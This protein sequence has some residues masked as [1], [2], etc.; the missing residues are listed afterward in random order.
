MVGDEQAEKIDKMADS[1]EGIDPSKFARKDNEIQRHIHRSGPQRGQIPVEN[2]Q[3]GFVYMRHPHIGAFQTEN[4]R[5][6]VR[7]SLEEAFRWG[8]EYVDHDDPEDRKFK[9]NDCAA[10]TNR[11]GIGDVMT[12]R[13]TVENFR[14]MQEYHREQQRRKGQVEERIVL[15]GA[16]AGVPAWGGDVSKDPNLAARFGAAAAQPIS[17]V[18]SRDG[19]QTAT[20]QFTE[21]DIRRG[22][23]P[24]VPVGTG[25]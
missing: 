20:A 11:R 16:G 3:P 15:L 13:I 2:P 8:W 14:K 12:L 22:S 5:V 9:G 7:A 1:L 25:A 4:A 19:G 18:Y 10:G 24:G 6:A 23:I 21:G 17:R